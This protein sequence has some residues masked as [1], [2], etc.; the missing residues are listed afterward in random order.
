MKIE[1]N[2]TS[3]ISLIV[4]ITI[5]LITGKRLDKESNRV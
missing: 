1:V 5:V 2:E 3:L 4:T